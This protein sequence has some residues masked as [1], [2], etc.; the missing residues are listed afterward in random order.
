M[1][2]QRGT[3]RRQVAAER[4]DVRIDHWPDRCRGGGRPGARCTTCRHGVALS[5]G[6]VETL[7]RRA[8]ARLAPEAAHQ[9][10]LALATPVACRDET[11]LRRGKRLGC[12]SSATTTSPATV[13]EPR[14]AV[15]KTYAGTAVHD[16]LAAYRHLPTENRHGR[17]HAHRLR[18][19]DEIVELA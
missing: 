18:N 11:G 17:G 7:C 15:W 8:A 4:V 1:A 13:W 19:Q 14:G 3:T 10:R 9:R 12:T 16:R 5:T 2:S 6:T